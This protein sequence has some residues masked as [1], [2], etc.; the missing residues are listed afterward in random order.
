[1]D[2]AEEDNDIIHVEGVDEGVQVHVDLEDAIG[3]IGAEHDFAFVFGHG[4]S[5][6]RS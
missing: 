2:V 4:R 1:M 3:Y 6:A 5:W